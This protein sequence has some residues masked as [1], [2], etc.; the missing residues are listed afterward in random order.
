[1]KSCKNHSIGLF[2]Y[3]DKD[4]NKKFFVLRDNLVPQNSISDKEQCE[5]NLNVMMKYIYSKSVHTK[6]YDD[7]QDIYVL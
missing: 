1:M 2:E 6:L 5:N 7:S 3:L 4:Q